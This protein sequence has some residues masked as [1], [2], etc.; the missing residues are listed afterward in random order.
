MHDKHTIRKIELFI[1]CVF[2]IVIAIFIPKRI[3]LGVKNIT[4][5]EKDMTYHDN[6]QNNLKIDTSKITAKAFVIF[7]V[8]SDKSIVSFHG[9]EKMPL[10]SVSKLMTGYIAQRD[11]NDQVKSYI[12]E[13]LITSSNT[14]AEQIAENCPN[15]EDF[16]K[17]M[18]KTAKDLGLDMTF[19]NASGLDIN[20]ETE[21]SNWGSPRS[22]A[23][24]LAVFQKE[25]P[26]VLEGT[27]YSNYEGL[28]NTN[29]YASN[30]PFL[31]GSKTGFTDTAG[32]NLATIF[33]PVFGHKICI[34]VFASSKENRFTDVYS[35]YK[36]YLKSL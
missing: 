28:K 25:Y 11:C 6:V 7:D 5:P 12:K 21:T 2:L 15:R 34:V 31:L 23:K 35:L 24:L 18:N 1:I 3:F 22:A 14:L 8:N 32:G 36:N 10:A 19:L 33:E 9:E 17:S 4:V 30:W 20:N 26:Q 29:T 13:M 16:L 27:T